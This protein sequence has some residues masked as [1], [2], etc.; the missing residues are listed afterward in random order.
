MILFF[1]YF[2]TKKIITISQS[3][4]SFSV[5]ASIL[6][7]TIIE[8]ILIFIYFNNKLIKNVEEIDE[9]EPSVLSEFS[10]SKE[11]IDISNM[12][13]HKKRYIKLQNWANFCGISALIFIY[14]GFDQIILAL[15]NITEIS[16]T[17]LATHEITSFILICLGIFFSIKF[18][19]S[20]RKLKKLL[21]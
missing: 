20:Y 16:I 7:L 9:S 3:Y 21:S 4:Y 10:H 15:D 17:L 12:I 8:F 6:I 19:L 2:F 14:A 13:K 1:V 5:V 11:N 18:W